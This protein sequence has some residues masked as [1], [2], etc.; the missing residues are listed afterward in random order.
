MDANTLSQTLQSA[1][2]QN[3]WNS[4][5]SNNPDLLISPL[6]D[7]VIQWTDIGY[8]QIEK[9]KIMFTDCAEGHIYTY[10]KTTPENND[11]TVAPISHGSRKEWKMFQDLFV[12]ASTSKLFRID[13]PISRQEVEVGEEIWEYTK[14]AHPGAGVGEIVDQH[15]LTP[16]TIETFLNNIIDPYYYAI[17]AAIKV[18]KNNSETGSP[19]LIPYIAIAHILEDR[20]GYYFAKNFDLWNQHPDKVVRQNIQVAQFLIQKVCNSETSADFLNQWTTTA[21]TRWTPLL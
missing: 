17:E 16:A 4:D 18:A 13:A 3:I 12:E 2:E 20:Q 1:V 11:S 7:F 8:Y 5:D 6:K 14:S 9:N 15:W 10:R 21:F 19:I